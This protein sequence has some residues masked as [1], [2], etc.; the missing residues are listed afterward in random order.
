MGFLLTEW[1]DG[2]GGSFYMGLKHGMVCLGC[3]WTQMLIMFAVGVMNLLGMALITLLVMLE[4][5]APVKRQ[6]I[7]RLVGILF[8][9][10]GIWLLQIG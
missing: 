6:L 1:R 5:M 4:K 9:G 7:C 8:I 3:C 10:W 2:A